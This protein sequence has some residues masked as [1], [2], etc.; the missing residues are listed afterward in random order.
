MLTPRVGVSKLSAKGLKVSILGFVVIYSLCHIL[1]KK[2]FFEKHKK[3]FFKI[4]VKY[5]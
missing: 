1:L 4:V 2:N 3:F 5:T